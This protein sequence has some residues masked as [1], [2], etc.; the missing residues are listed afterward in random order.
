MFELTQS[1]AWVDAFYTCTEQLIN[2][3]LIYKVSFVYKQA[4][5]GKAGIYVIEVCLSLI[6]SWSVPSK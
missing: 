4:L 1:L 2:V 5:A 3:S 6:G